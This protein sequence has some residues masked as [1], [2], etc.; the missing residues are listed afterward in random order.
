MAWFA[1]PKVD[2]VLVVDDD[3]DVAAYIQ[4]VLLTAGVESIVAHDGRTAI[5]LAQAELPRLILLDISMPD[6]DGLKTLT[7]LRVHEET[8]KIPVLMVTA[9]QT[10]K[11]VD[12]AFQRGAVGYVIKPIDLPR[13]LAKVGMFVTIKGG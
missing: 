7:Q 13:F 3:P 11:D 2:R 12:E 10:G 9:H 1:K 8:R 5:K 4:D 6:W